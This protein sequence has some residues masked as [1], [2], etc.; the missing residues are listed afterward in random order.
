VQ[1]GI[2]A[3]DLGDFA[4]GFAQ[5]IATIVTL[6]LAARHCPVRA[7]GFAFVGPMSVSDLADV[8]FHQSRR[9]PL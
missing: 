5:M 8:F 1:A 2:A 9:L 4:D 3:T 7:E 6:T